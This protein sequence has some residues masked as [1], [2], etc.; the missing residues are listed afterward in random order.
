M[1]CKRML[2]DVRQLECRNQSV[3]PRLVGMLVP[4]VLMI[5]LFANQ[6]LNSFK[7]VGLWA[8]FVFG[9]LLN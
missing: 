6:R 5:S 1:P 8:I 3:W 4:H 2:L 9:L 7:L